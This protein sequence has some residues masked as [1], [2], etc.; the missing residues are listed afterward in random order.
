M[1]LA[2]NLENVSELPGFA[3][4]KFTVQDASSALAVEAAGICPGNTVMDLCAAPGLSLIH[5][6]V[7][8]GKNIT[9][10]ITAFSAPVN[11]IYEAKTAVIEK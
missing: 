1:Y 6:C 3:E 8:A 11:E 10:F 2:Q 5:I 4:G 7:I 9:E